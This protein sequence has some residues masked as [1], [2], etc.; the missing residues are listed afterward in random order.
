MRARYPSSPIGAGILIVGALVTVIGVTGGFL[1]ERGRADASDDGGPVWAAAKEATR[2]S[3][4]FIA[5]N[6]DSHVTVSVL[7]YDPGQ[8]SGLAPGTVGS[9]PSRS[10][11]AS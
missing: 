10:C 4:A 5:Q 9:T 6:L 8:S 11:P 3:P 1:H 7:T 2:G